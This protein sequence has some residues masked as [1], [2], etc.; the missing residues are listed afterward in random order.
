[1]GYQVVFYFV[2]VL[3]SFFINVLIMAGVIPMKGNIRK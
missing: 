3:F 1:M 2:A